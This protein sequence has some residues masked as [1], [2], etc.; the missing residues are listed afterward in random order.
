MDHNKQPH[1]PVRGMTA[2]GMLRITVA[3]AFAAMAALVT[4]TT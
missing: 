1:S 2:G 4:M 3:A